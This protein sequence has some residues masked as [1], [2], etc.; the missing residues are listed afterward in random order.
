MLNEDETNK[1]EDIL[2]KNNNRISNNRI[3][4][5]KSNNSKKRLKSVTI[6]N[7]K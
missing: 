4:I 2:F 3:S 7:K 6:I 1:K 5:N